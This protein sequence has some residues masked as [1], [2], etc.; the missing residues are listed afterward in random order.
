MSNKKG[1]WNPPSWPWELELITLIFFLAA[2]LVPFYF[3]SDTKTIAQINEAAANGSFTSGQDL[4]NTQFGFLWAVAIVAVYIMHL[5]FSFIE[6]D[7]VTASPVHLLSPCVFAVLAYYRVDHIPNLHNTSLSSIDGSLSQVLALIV[8]VGLVT[9]ILARLRKY[10]YLL[11]FDDVQWEI[12]TPAVYDAS[13]FSMMLVI[14]PLLYAP[15]QYRA[16]S[17]GILIEGWFYASP[18][19]FSDMRAI[20]ILKTA[21]T[22]SSG[23]LY[24]ASSSKNLVRMELYDSLKQTYISPKNRE[25]FVR[26]CIQHIARKKPSSRKADPTRHDMLRAADTRAGDTSSS[27]TRHS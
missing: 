6:M 27:A 15:R 8:V 2:L 22:T 3:T 16:C 1:K 12:T 21:S 5:T 19:S 24:Y 23:G 10:R 4:L 26:Y 11:E 17:D 9:S 18:I 7:R 14:R 20:A 25:E 13:Y